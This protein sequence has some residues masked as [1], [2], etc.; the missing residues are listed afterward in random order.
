MSLEARIKK[1]VGEDAEEIN[2]DEV[3]IFSTLSPYKSSDKNDLIISFVF[4]SMIK[5]YI[6]NHI[7]NFIV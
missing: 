6:F 3:S 2:P 7:F 1:M 4:C 5:E